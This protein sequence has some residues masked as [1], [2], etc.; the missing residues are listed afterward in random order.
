MNKDQPRLAINLVTYNAEKYLPF[1]LPSV[2]NQTLKDFSFLVIDNGSSDNTL[3]HLAENYPQVRVVSYPKNLGF[4]KTHNQA[5]AWSKTDYLA[6]LNQDV[7]LEPDYFEKVVSYLDGHL[8]AAA[9]GG[10]ILRWDFGTNS[11]TKYI[12][13]LG[14]LV[15]KNHRV[16]EIGQGEIDKGQYN[17]VKEVF[18]LSGALPTFRRQV[19]EKIKVSLPKNFSRQEYFDEDFFAYKEDVDLAFRLRLAGFKSFYLPEAVAYHDRSVKGPRDLSDR[20]VRKSRSR[21]DKMVKAYSYKNHLLML[22][23]NEFKR[24]LIRFGWP[25]C[26]YEFKK[27]AFIFLFEQSTIRGLKMFLKQKKKNK[28]KRKYIYKNLVKVKP[29]D[30]AKWYE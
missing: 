1:C 9:V 24:N 5:I 20:A 4:A 17:E 18:G 25:I 12:D 21:K 14:L 23:K 11:R 3:S 28:L 16:V 27:L 22:F 26:W 29:N 19:L 7:I 2:L 10:K 13:S 15:F 6:L 30:L 8:E